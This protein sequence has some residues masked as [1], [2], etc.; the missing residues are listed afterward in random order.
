M[1]SEDH[2]ATFGSPQAPPIPS[3]ASKPRNWRV[4]SRLVVGAAMAGLFLVF[5]LQNVESVDVEFLTWSFSMA[6]SLLMILCGIAGAV[7]WEIAGFISRRA[8]RKR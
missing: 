6:G 4:I 7:V 1:D 2:N 3:K 8:R 5:V